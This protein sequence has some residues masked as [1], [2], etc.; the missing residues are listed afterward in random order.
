MNIV[1][2]EPLG[3]SEELLRK[4]AAPL[5]RAGHTVTLCTEKLSEEEK[6]RRAAEADVF[7]IANGK[8]P[9]AVI[10]A[11]PKLKMISVGFTGVDFPSTACPN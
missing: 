7:I 6:L 3:V 5:E 9:R 1:M 8:L 10:D 11:A 2:L 4:K